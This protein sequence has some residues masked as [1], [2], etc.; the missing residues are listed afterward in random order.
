MW[1]TA[2][3]TRCDDV[4]KDDDDMGDAWREYRRAQQQRRGDRLGPRTAE[5]EALAGKGFD[6]RT[7]SAYQ[8]RIDGTLDLYPIHRRFHHLPTQQRGGYRHPLDV[9]MRF[10]RRGR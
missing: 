5:I 10:L 1:G 6:V 8:F 2:R 7:L 4:A 9:A 3:R